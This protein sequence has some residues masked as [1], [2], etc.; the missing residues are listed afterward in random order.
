MKQSKVLLSTY[1]V[2]Y[3]NKD[4]EQD[5]I[6]PHGIYPT[7][8]YLQ[9]APV[10]ACGH[11]VLSQLEYSPIIFTTH[12]SGQLLPII[13][14]CN[15][16]ILALECE[17]GPFPFRFVLRLVWS[18]CNIWNSKVIL[19]NMIGHANHRY[20]E[21]LLKTLIFQVSYEII[22]LFSLRKAQELAKWMFCIVFQGLSL[23]LSLFFLEVEEIEAC[24]LR[25]DKTIEFKSLAH[26]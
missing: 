8:S 14:K 21:F 22:A 2:Q 26:Q 6:I 25:E 5:H 4:L 24:H 11:P 20:D 13:P 10:M 23:S 12:C 7:L 3:Y 1:S 15:L 19:K 9:Q 16:V 18:S 17:L